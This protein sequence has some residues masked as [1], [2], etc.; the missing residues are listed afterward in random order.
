MSGECHF[1]HGTVSGFE[2]DHILLSDHADHEVYMHEQC[3]A[4]HNAIEKAVGQGDAIEV[5]CPVCG[6]VETH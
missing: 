4:G 2:S 1:C 6:S 5:T 3:A